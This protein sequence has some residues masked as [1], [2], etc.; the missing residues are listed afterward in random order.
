MPTLRSFRTVLVLLALVLGGAARAHAQEDI[1]LRLFRPQVD[2]SGETFQDK[3]FDGTT[4]GEYGADTLSFA[5]NIPLGKTHV[6]WDR[7]YRASQ[8]FAHVVASRATPDITFL[9]GEPRKLY[10]GLLAASGVWLS[11]NNNLYV[12]SAGGSFA[13]DDHTIRDLK[14]RFYALFLG[15]HKIRE[16]FT[17][18]YGGAATYQ[19]AR[20]L[21]LPVIGAVWWINPKW[22]L[23]GI[24][25]FS[26]AASYR[27]RDNLSLLLSLG[28][29]G[30]RYRFSNQGE[31]PGR[32]E[33]VFLSTLQSRATAQLD[34]KAGRNVSLYVQGG[35]VTTVQLVFSEDA[36]IGS[37]KF[38]DDS[39]QPAG[40]L[41]GGVRF[42]FGKSI[43][44]EWKK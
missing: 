32:P 12:A 4:P 36:A 33:T 22:T 15:T 2:I 23:V 43:L 44:D 42:T 10:T 28:F 40:F 17:L 8:F 30:N 1:D 18:V 21:A 24:L 5:A 41:K 7:K 20:G 25:P 13:E 19:F 34:W 16:T 38:I 29:S 27:V 14:G 31:F 35:T 9:T 11:R 39:A 26:V 6:R 37:D 3:P